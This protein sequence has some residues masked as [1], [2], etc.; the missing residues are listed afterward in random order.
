M[1][2]IRVEKKEGMGSAWIWILLLALV[3]AAAIWFFSQSRVTEGPAD[4]TAPGEV[5]PAGGAG[6]ATPPPPAN[7]TSL[8]APARQPLPTRAA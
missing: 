5:A 7:P 6:T 4:T 1:A 8:Q 3:I 2:E